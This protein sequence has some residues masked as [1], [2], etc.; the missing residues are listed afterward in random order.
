MTRRLAIGSAAI[1]AALAAKLKL[2]AILG[3]SLTEATI[4]VWLGENVGFAFTSILLAIGVSLIIYY[5]VTKW[6]K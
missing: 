3:I 5:I 6:K 2:F 4:D 1:V